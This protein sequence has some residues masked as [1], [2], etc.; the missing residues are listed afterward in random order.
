MEKNPQKSC[1]VEDSETFLTKLGATRDKK[2]C[3]LLTW[4][5]RDTDKR[6]ISNCIPKEYFSGGAGALRDISSSILDI[7]DDTE[8]QYEINWTN[9]ALNIANLVFMLAN[10]FVWKYQRRELPVHEDTEDLPRRARINW[11]VSDVHVL[12]IFI[13]KRL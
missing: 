4:F 10:I 8:G 12:R 5:M 7:E 3:L 11:Q 1:N 6:A 13:I 2:Y 9:I